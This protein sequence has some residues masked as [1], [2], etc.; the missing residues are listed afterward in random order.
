LT[1]PCEDGLSELEWWRYGDARGYSIA[2]AKKCCDVLQGWLPKE[3]GITDF[4]FE[5]IYPSLEYH[6]GNEAIYIQVT[7]D[8]ETF[9]PWIKK[10]IAGNGAAW[11]EYLLRYKSRAGFISFY[12]HD[13]ADWAAALDDANTFLN[14]NIKDRRTGKFGRHAFGALLQFYFLVEEGDDAEQRLYDQVISNIGP[15]ERNL[16]QPELGKEE[17]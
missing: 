11:A 13:P 3:S 4:D 9:L 6:F 17:T 7:V 8:L 2:L 14:L 5:E 16:S 15:T 12:S 10:F 1:P